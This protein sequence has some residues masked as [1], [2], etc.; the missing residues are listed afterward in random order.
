[1][2]NDPVTQARLDMAHTDLEEARAADLAALDA[3]ALVMMVERLRASLHDALHL[4]DE[5]TRATA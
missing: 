3:V 1:M 2:H 4:L 5:T